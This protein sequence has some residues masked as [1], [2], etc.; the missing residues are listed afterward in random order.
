MS[1]YKGIQT[2][3]LINIL[4][5]AEFW[6]HGNI[7]LLST[8]NKSENQKVSDYLECSRHT[9]RYYLKTLYLLV[10][11]LVDKKPITSFKGIEGVT[12]IKLLEFANLMIKGE[13]QLKNYA[14]NEKYLFLRDIKKLLNISSQ[15]TIWS[16]HTT[17][18]QLTWIITKEFE[19]EDKHKFMYYFSSAI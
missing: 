18:L 12:L 4:K 13:I 15:R 17:L 14:N 19:S 6:K 5:L 10:N 8:I 7:T 1:F 9:A 2:K 3:I 16:Y 11:H